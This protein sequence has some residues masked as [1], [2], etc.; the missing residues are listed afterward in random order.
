MLRIFQPIFT[1]CAT[2]LLLGWGRPL[3][4]QSQCGTANSVGFPVD[5]AQFRL[6]QDF[7]TPSYRHQG[8]YHTGEDWYGGANS[9]GAEVRAIA[10]GRVTFSSGNGW[11][12]DGGVIILEHIMPDGTTAYSMYGHITEATGITFPSVFTCVSQGDVIAAVGEPRPAPHLHFEIRADKPDIPGPGYTWEDPALDGWRQPSKFVANW[13]AWSLASH[14]WHADIADEAGPVAPPVELADLSLLVLDAN[15]VL[16]VSPDGRVLW[17]VILERQ[18]VGLVAQGDAGLITYADGGFQPVNLDGTLGSVRQSGIALDSPP[19][20]LGDSLV[21]HT[22]DNGLVAFSA[23]AALTRWQ[24]PNIPTV[25]RWAVAG[26]TLGLMT[27]DNAM[28]T[29]SAAGELAD[30][31]LLREPGSL[32][33]STDLIAY[34]RGGLWRV[35]ANG[36]WSLSF[37]DAPPGGRSSAVAENAQQL[38]LFDGATLHAYANPQQPAA[39]WATSLPGVN[40]AVSLSLYD[41]IVLLTSSYGDI[42]AVQA[43]SGGICNA[44]RIYGSSRAREWHSLGSDGILRVYVADGII[45]LA[46][47]RFLMACR[48]A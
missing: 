37:A 1:I 22:P 15:R 11:G 26:T 10:D 39:Q 43:S 36:T 40:G 17:R 31:A 28:L 33:A 13:Q 41:D 16:R 9:Y 12:R 34:T 48:P 7:G 23:D 35:A 8:R 42:I 4:A 47:D 45:G 5:P 29:V 25:L 19:I 24:L 21:F 44:T 38:F 27:N 18:A 46:W 32:T 3:L 30:Y 6:V 14:R 20:P 2:L